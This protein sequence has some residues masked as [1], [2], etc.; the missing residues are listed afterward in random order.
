CFG[1]AAR[2]SRQGRIGR[3]RAEHAADAGACGRVG[4]DNQKRHSGAR[5]SA[6]PESRGDSTRSFF[7]A[8]YAFQPTL[9]AKTYLMSPATL[10]ML[11]GKIAAGKSTLTTELGRAPSTIVIR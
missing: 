6:N 2:Q 4:A 1:C 3:R 5:V 8:N 10:H 7:S 11:C 9:R